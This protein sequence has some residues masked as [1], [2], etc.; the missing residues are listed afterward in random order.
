MLLACCC[1]AVSSLAVFSNPG[2]EV[3][4]RKLDRLPLFTVANPEGLPLKYQVGDAERALFYAEIESAKKE[5]EATRAEKKDIEC[6]LIPIGLGVAYRLSCEGKALI[7][8]GEKDLLRAGAPQGAPALGQALPL[9]ACMEVRKSP[10]GSPR[11]VCRI[12]NL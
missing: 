6:D 4:Q 9:F 5:L 12:L 10:V 2:W 3:L 7:V 8:P 11:F 1:S